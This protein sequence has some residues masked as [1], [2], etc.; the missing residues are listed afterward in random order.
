LTVFVRY[1]LAYSSSG[2]QPVRF[3]P[4]WPAFL[5]SLFY[6]LSPWLVDGVLASPLGFRLD[7]APGF[8]LLPLFGLLAGLVV[9]G[10]NFSTLFSGQKAAVKDRALYLI[11]VFFLALFFFGAS[12]LLPFLAGTVNFSSTLPLLMAIGVVFF[13]CAHSGYFLAE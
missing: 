1:S 2:L 7:Y 10:L 12:L 13:A 4:Y 11:L 8:W 5:V 9:L 3:W 6:F